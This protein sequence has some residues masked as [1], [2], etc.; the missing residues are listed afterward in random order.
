MISGAEYGRPY[1]VDLIILIVDTTNGTELRRASKS[2]Y[3]E[4]IQISRPEL[5][6]VVPSAGLLVS[7]LEK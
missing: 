7:S 4:Y 1:A 6:L 3:F 2:I 5:E